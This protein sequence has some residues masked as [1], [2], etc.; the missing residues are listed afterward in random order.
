MVSVEEWV[1]TYDGVYN[2]CQKVERRSRLE[3]ALYWQTLYSPIAN[4]TKTLICLFIRQISVGVNSSKN[5]GWAITFSV[6]DK[7]L[8]CHLRNAIACV[9]LLPINFLFARS[10]M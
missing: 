1:M 9:K 3:A 5:V 4:N 8:Q 2:V 6:K 7:N 10:N